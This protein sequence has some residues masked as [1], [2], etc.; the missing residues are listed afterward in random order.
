[1]ALYRH[2]KTL[3]TMNQKQ[4]LDAM[5]K[6]EHKYRTGSFDYADAS[7]LPSQVAELKSWPDAPR[8]ALRLV[9]EKYAGQGTGQAVLSAMPEFLEA[10]AQRRT[11]AKNRS[12][13]EFECRDMMGEYS[14]A[15]VFGKAPNMGTNPRAYV[16]NGK[17]ISIQVS[18]RPCKLVVDCD[19]MEAADSYVFGLYVPVLK[20]AWLLGWARK[21]D[22]LACPKGNRISD[23][24]N[25]VWARM[26]HYMKF[27]ALRPL[28]DLLSQHGIKQISNGLLFERVPAEADLV[29]PSDVTITDYLTPGNDPGADFFKILG[30][31]EETTK[32][33]QATDEIQSI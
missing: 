10:E 16:E 21:S 15:Q 33:P 13:P 23:P 19:R 28:A 14:L 9:V 5:L 2:E 25:C 27:D 17:P 6:A 7:L 24:E 11:T 30:M 29:I 8:A 1:M 18:A 26:G 22:M 20:R 32:R 3:V 12:N 4:V 31:E